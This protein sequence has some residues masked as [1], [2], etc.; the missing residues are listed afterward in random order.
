MIKDYSNRAISIRVAGSVRSANVMCVVQKRI[1]GMDEG[2]SMAVVL[3]EETQGEGG[4]WVVTPRPVKLH[5][6]LTTLLQAKRTTQM[7]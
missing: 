5:K 2:G 7:L 4:H 1:Q 6:Q 3:G